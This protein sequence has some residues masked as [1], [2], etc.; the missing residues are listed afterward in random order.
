MARCRARTL[1][2]ELAVGAPPLQILTASCYDVDTDVRDRLDAAYRDLFAG[3]PGPDLSWIIGDATYAD[4]AFW[5][6]STMARYTPR[7]YA[8]L[9]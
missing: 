7:T 8:L 1:P 5:L 9:E 6:Y 2:D 4:A 3:I